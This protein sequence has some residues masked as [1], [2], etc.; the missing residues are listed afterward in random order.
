MDRGTT[1]VEV[2]PVVVGS[3]DFDRTATSPEPAQPV[4]A[5]R[6]PQVLHPAHCQRNL[7][8]VPECESG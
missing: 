3:N 5:I 1:L 4:M 6:P 8:K 2:G 7:P